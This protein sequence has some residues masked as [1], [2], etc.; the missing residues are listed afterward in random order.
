[1]NVK[2]EL[3]QRRYD[4]DWLRVLAI[5]TVFIYH[6]CRFFNLGDWHVKNATTY[7]GV[8]LG[9]SF[10]ELWMMPLIF[11][12]SGASVFYAI[13]KG[14]P[15]RFIQDKV[16][17]LLVPLLVGAFSHA[18]LQVYLERLTHGQFHGSYWAFLPHYF[19]GWY[20][21]GGSGNFAWMGMHL[22]YL[23][24]LF[25]FSL[26]LAPLFYWLKGGFGGRVLRGL[27]D[28]LALPGAV[29]LFALPTILMENL[30]DPGGPQPG[31]WSML[32]YLWFFL[33]GFVLISHQ[34]LGQRIVQMRWVSLALGLALVVGSLVFSN[35][36]DAHGDLCSWCWILAI[37]GFGMRH[38]TRNTPFLKYANQAVLPFY[39]LHQ[40]VLLGVGYFV[41]GWAIPD[42]L[43]YVLITAS[44]FPIILVLYEFLV[45]R[46]NLLR[47][48]FGMKPLRRAAQPAG[49]S[50]LPQTAKS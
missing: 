44:S 19:D 4:L 40:T 27:G 13:G 47:V 22:W 30:L 35:E 11:L 12:I 43:K 18:S 2:T 5:L 49:P 24:V 34:R 32:Q 7:V 1:M 36:I 16:L 17:R 20:M 25:V 3:T 29:Y 26:V 37:L 50:P 9:L 48:L 10:G 33:A 23:L 21:E 41:V 8:S 31:G 46:S 14:G 45:R 6:S 38:L 42:L 15:G 28:F 39:I